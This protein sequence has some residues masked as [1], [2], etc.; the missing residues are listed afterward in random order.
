ML[1]DQDG[2]K[3]II[4]REWAMLSGTIRTMLSTDDGGTYA[5]YFNHARIL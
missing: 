5:R 1:M 2:Y 3:F 4:D